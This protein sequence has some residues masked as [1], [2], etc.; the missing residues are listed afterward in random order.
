M[1]IDYESIWVVKALAEG[2]LMEVR[3]K[4]YSAAQTQASPV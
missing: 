3:T 2:S 1:R 4:P